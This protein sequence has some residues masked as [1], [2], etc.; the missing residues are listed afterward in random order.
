[1]NLELEQAETKSLDK[2]GHQYVPIHLP[3]GISWEMNSRPTDFLPQVRVDQEADAE[4]SR[5]KIRQK[6]WAHWPPPTGS[7]P[8][9][10]LED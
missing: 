7:M 5:A 10:S 1:M 9:V 8:M 4:I 6:L 3:T 2:W